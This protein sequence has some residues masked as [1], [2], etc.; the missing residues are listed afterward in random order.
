MNILLRFVPA[1][2]V[3][4]GSVTFDGAHM[5]EY[6]LK[7]FRSQVSVVFQETMILEGTVKDNIAFGSGASDKDIEE[8]ARQSDIHDFIQSLPEKYD[9]AIGSRGNF[10]G[11]QL[12]RICIARALC[13]KPSLLLLDEATS[14]L[15][16]VTERGI[17]ET[18]GRLNK[19]TN[20]TIVSVSHHPDT[21]RHVDQIVYL[22]N[23][24]VEELGTYDE[25][26]EMKGGF[27][28]LAS[29]TR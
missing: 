10:S 2:S 19:E 16:P 3:L 1:S 5:H 8:A 28:Q 4:N 20:I 15:D 27:A 22:K 25:L 14:A 23:G 11:G 7:S 18:L 21:A 17:V 13:R 26:L 9:T 6:S 24:R 12:Q 29:S